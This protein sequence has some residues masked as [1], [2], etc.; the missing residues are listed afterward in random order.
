L[1]TVEFLVPYLNRKLSVA[2]KT[3]EIPRIPKGIVRPTIVAGINSLGRGQDAVSL[4]Q[5]LQTIAQTMGPEAIAQFINPTEVVK[6]LAA[7]QGIDILNLVRSEEELNQQQMAAQQQQEQAQ[8]M[9][10]AIA[11]SKTPLM[12]PTK[13]PQLN[14]DLQSAAE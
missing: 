4:G 5:F 7:A 6:R 10:Q 11:M 8:N 2:Q 3:G 14:A 1:L 9:E 12:D 13:N